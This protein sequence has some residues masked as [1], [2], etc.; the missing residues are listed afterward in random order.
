MAEIYCEL[1]RKSSGPRID[2][3][4]HPGGNPEASRGLVGHASDIFGMIHSRGIRGHGRGIHSPRCLP[5]YRPHLRK[6]IESRHIPV[7]MVHDAF[8]G[9]VNVRTTVGVVSVL[10]RPALEPFFVAVRSFRVSTDRTLLTRVLRVN[11][12]TVTPVG[13]PCSS[14]TIDCEIPSRRWSPR[15]D[16]FRLLSADKSIVYGQ[17]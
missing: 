11:D 7:L 9:D 14:G 12:T 8:H 1:P 16:L 5:S 3:S 15:V 2:D 4:R 6:A 13:S 10:A 17:W